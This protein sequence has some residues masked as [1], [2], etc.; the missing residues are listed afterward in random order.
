MKTNI[1]LFSLR[2][3]CKY[4]TLSYNIFANVLYG[5]E[6]PEIKYDYF[7]DCVKLQ[8]PQ[9]VLFCHSRITRLAVAS[10]SSEVFLVK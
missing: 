1:F 10:G 2:K 9:K 6:T 7:V 8:Q 4:Y 3:V 5:S